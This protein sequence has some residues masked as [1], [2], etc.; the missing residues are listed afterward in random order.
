ME[1]IVALIDI[2]FLKTD[3]SLTKF[4]H[5]QDVI[6][7]EHGTLYQVLSISNFLVYLPV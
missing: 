3:P 6:L 5:L 7:N 4:L 2:F 1:L